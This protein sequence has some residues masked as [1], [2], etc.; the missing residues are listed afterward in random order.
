VSQEFASKLS[1]VTV[2][3]EDL[4]HAANAINEMPEAERDW[5]GAMT[6]LIPLFIDEP[7][8]LLAVRSRLFSV[9]R[10]VQTKGLPA[11]THATAATEAKFDTAVWL[12]AATEPLVV[13]EEGEA[14]FER[15]SFVRR[16]LSIATSRGHA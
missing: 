6:A 9:S 5:N 10:I 3:V 15:G 8:K 11:W 4:A 13:T 14:S 2:S 7:D 1:S 12:A 16:V